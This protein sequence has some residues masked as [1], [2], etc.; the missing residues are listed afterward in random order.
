TLARSAP[1]STREPT[2]V[3]TAPISTITMMISIRLMPDWPE[4]RRERVGRRGWGM[5]GSWRSGKREQ[6]TGN[7]EQ[8]TGNREQGTGWECA[9]FGG[10]GQ[11]CRDEGVSGVSRLRL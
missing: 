4:A 6:G 8:G 2:K 1:P 5:G 7:R 10:T 3:S 11:P 9:G